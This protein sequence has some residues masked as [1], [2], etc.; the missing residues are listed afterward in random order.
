MQKP[1]VLLVSQGA[2]AT[3]FSRVADGIIRHLQG[4]YY[5]H[6]FAINVRKNEVEGDWPIYGNPDPLDAHGL[7]RLCELVK[8]TRP[9]IVLV[10][11]DLWFCCIHIKR[12]I[13]LV[14]RPLIIGYCP[15][16]G[17]L[18]RPSLYEGLALFDHVVAYN[19]FGE[20]E[21][22]KIEGVNKISKIPHGLDTNAFY[23]L[24]PECLIDRSMAKELLLGECAHEN[25][26][27]VLNAAKHQLRK[28]IDLTIEGFALFAKDKPPDVKL[29]LHTGATFNGPDIRAMV[30][31]AGITDRLI[32]SA[33][34]LEDHPVVDEE[35]LN[36]LY[37]ATEVGINT[38]MGEGWGLLS[39][40]HAA[41]GAPQI[42][43]AHTACGE[44]WSGVDTILP[45]RSSMEHTGLAMVWHAIDPAD[46]ARILNQLYWDEDYRKQQAMKAYQ[47]ATQTSYRWENIAE[48]WSRLFQQLL[49]QKNDCI[50]R[51][52]KMMI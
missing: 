51:Q 18:T 14:P 17:E 10:L 16:D 3:G 48:Q 35:A 32:H 30:E 36:L 20:R 22:S 26:F 2:A 6:Q 43:P 29:F 44:L 52:K 23:P 24:Q 41:T 12:L 40:E 8:Q 45:V 47:N 42:V 34:W 1:T 33:G 37:N 31:K 4:E 39:F 11:Y 46:I 5:F 25:G 19:S 15:V 49:R 27:I 38:A 9:A 7:D 28:R 21:I 50:Q 13:Q